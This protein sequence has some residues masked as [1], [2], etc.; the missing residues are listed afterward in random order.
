M[1][2][3]CPYGYVITPATE[4][5]GQGGPKARSLCVLPLPPIPGFSSWLPYLLAG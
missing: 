2:G 1:S 4:N 3:T 5:A